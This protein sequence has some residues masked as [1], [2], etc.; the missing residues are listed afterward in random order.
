MTCVRIKSQKLLQYKKLKKKNVECSA[1]SLYEKSPL[2]L[3]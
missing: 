3:E 2:G 1:Q